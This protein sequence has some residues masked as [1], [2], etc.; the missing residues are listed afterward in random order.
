MAY[1]FRLNESAL[2]GFEDRELRRFM[3]SLQRD[4]EEGAKALCPVDT[5]FTR[6]TIGGSTSPPGFRPIRIEV[7]VGGAGE[8]IN[9]GT[10]PHKIRARNASVLAN[11]DTVFGKEVNHPGTAPNPFLRRAVS[12]ALVR[13][14]LRPI[15]S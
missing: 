5:G 1:R 8:F 12:V 15:R 10:R 9:K 4:A 2:R 13:H 11:A 7:T 3:A 6:S 14:G